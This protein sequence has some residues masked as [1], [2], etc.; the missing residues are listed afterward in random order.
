[1]MM[2]AQYIKYGEDEWKAEV[3]RRLEKMECFADETKHNFDKTLDWLHEWACSR[4]AQRS[5]SR[6]ANSAVQL[7][8]KPKN[9]KIGG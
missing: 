2:H 1:M 7:Y 8:L 6:D 3:K 4:Y 9:W 5:I